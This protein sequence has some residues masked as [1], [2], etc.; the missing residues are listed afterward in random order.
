M[1]SAAFVVS[2]VSAMIY[3]SLAYFT[4]PR[5]NTSPTRK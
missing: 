3:G 2:D 5:S 4:L 1:N